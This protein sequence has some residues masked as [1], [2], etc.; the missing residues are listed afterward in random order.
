MCTKNKKN[1]AGSISI[2]DI[3]AFLF[4]LNWLELMGD[5]W[6]IGRKLIKGM[7]N[8]GV[9]EVLEYQTTLELLNKQGRKAIIHK[10]Q[11]VRYLQNNILAYQDQA[12][13][14]GKILQGYRCSPGTPV[15]QYRLGYKT[16]VLI[17]LR[18]VK[19]KG[20]VDDFNI[21]W[22][23]VDG[24]LKKD[25]FWG[26]AINHKTRKIK[27]QIIFPKDRP[28]I[29]ASIFETNLRRTRLLGEDARRKTPDGHWMISWEK[30]NPRLYE[31][32]L[33]KWEW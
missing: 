16:Y 25:G 27:V 6:K 17:S 33:L 11:K 7:T 3:I 18:E 19:E 28:P 20:D 4:D 9:Y 22:K 29:R 10:R 8:E 21:K 14:D 2:S 32:Y 26:T 13:G 24:F 30:N 31:N 23:M 15:D 5:L 1:N 12:W